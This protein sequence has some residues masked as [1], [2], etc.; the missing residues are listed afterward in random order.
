[1]TIKCEIC[2]FGDLT[3]KCSRHPLNGGRSSTA[4]LVKQMHQATIFGG[5]LWGNMI[6][7]AEQTALA[8]MSAADK[9]ALEAKK[10]AEEAERKKNII[11]YQVNKRK[12]LYTTAD[13]LAKR[14]YNRMCKRERYDG[15]CIVHNEKHGACSFVHKDERPQYETIFASFGMKMVDDAAYLMLRAKVDTVAGE[16]KIKMKS[17]CDAM[18]EKLKRE[19]RC[20]FIKGVDA[21]GNLVFERSDKDDK[22]SRSTPTDRKDGWFTVKKDNGAW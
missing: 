20:L 7:E 19:M 6:W 4:Q 10:A 17:D 16:V 1:M 15:G 8:R 5:G 21:T 2:D 3:A 18:E 9:A 22:S 13:G 12:Q 14:K 11:A